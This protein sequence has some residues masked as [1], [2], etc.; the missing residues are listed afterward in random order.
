MEGDMSSKQKNKYIN[1]F[2]DHLDS[3]SAIEDFSPYF[4]ASM[5]LFAKNYY[6]YSAQ[7]ADGDDDSGGTVPPPEYPPSPNYM[8]NFST[9]CETEMAFGVNLD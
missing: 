2:N 9:K 7:D 5:S 3:L 1:N 4:E 6:F 8:L